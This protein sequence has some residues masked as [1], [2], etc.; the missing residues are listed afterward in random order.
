[1]LDQRD[2]LWFKRLVPGIKINKINCHYKD[3][4]FWERARKRGKKHIICDRE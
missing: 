3:V 4:A 1:M 2:K